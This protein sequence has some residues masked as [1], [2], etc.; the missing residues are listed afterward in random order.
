MCKLLHFS[1][2]QN[3]VIHYAHLGYKIHSNHSNLLAK[4]IKHE[5][6]KYSNSAIYLQLN[7]GVRRRYY[8]SK[9]VTRD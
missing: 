6:E 3:T 5:P 4:Q 7:F 1:K 8:W 2:N 9:K